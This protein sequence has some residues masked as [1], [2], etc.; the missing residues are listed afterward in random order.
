[1]SK[2]FDVDLNRD[3]VGDF[4]H[5]SDEIN[6]NRVDKVEVTINSRSQY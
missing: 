3:R 6:E 2:L 4:M 1:M 5:R